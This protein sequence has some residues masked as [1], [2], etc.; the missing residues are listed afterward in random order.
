MKRRLDEKRRG[1][2]L[3]DRFTNA[4]F[5]IDTKPENKCFRNWIF[6]VGGL[7][8]QTRNSQGLKRDRDDAEL[9]PP[10]YCASFGGGSTQTYLV[11]V[12]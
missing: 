10:R 2:Q 11:A 12:G 3:T 8:T 5:T 1:T 9:Q 6:S 7:R 4:S